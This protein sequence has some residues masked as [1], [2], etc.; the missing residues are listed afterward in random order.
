MDDIVKVVCDSKLQFFF[1]GELAHLERSFLKDQIKATIFGMG[2]HKA[3]GPNGL[4][5]FFFQ[6]Y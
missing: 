1:L 5:A 2:P 3:L 4:Y 6:N